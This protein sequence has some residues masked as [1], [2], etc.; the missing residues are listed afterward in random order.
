M[1]TVGQQGRW[2]YG[3]GPKTITL[4]V[5]NLG[6]ALHWQGLWHAFA[7][8][9]K[10]VDA[11]IANKCNRRGKRFGFVRFA[12]VADADRATMRLNGFHLYGNKLSVSRAKFNTRQSYWRKVRAHKFK[13]EEKSEKGDKSDLGKSKETMTETSDSKDKS[14]TG[15]ERI[16]GHVETEDLWKYKKCLVGTMATVCSTSS[17]QM[18]LHEWGLGEIVV[19]R[20]GGKTFLL[21]I[22]D[23]DLFMMLEDVNWSHL[24]EIFVEISF[25]SEKVIQRDRTIWIKVTG[26]PLHCWNLV[27]L[28][29]VAA[30]WGSFEALGENANQCMDCEKVTV[31]I[32]TKQM[33]KISEVI[34]IEVDSFV[35]KMMVMEIGFS[36]TPKKLLS[37]KKDEDGESSHQSSHI[38]TESSADS[39]QD[40]NIAKPIPRTDDVTRSIGNELE[41]G[42]ECLPTG[43][44]LKRRLGECVNNDGNATSSGKEKLVEKILSRKKKKLVEKSGTSQDVCLNEGQLGLAIIAGGADYGVGLKSSNGEG[45]VECS[46]LQNE[47]LSQQAVEDIKF[48]G[49]QFD[50]IISEENLKRKSSWE[51]AVDE[52]NKG[53]TRINFLGKTEFSENKALTEVEKR[54]R[55]RGTRKEK[56]EDKC[57]VESELSSRS[58]SDSDIATRRDIQTREARKALQIGKRIGIQIVGDESAAIS[59]IAGILGKSD[60]GLQILENMMKLPNFAF[61]H[62]SCPEKWA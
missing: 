54:K 36:D 44:K 43:I 39:S 53:G 58:L 28:K 3:Q 31:L 9:G 11:F 37:P 52:Q 29:K 10:V 40:R 13:R 42:E 50:N 49:L 62:D 6:K 15:I 26:L 61:F 25:W 30:L 27:T 18:R 1:T 55:D 19:K 4:Y 38:Q 56:K 51:A 47:A 20:L 12:T 46:P 35:Y 16:N 23:E 2:K 17:V 7:R 21:S 22:E 57:Q 5:E 33:E 45:N 24:K 60:P 32:T 59:D 34:E 8:H 41:Y 14:T 48:M